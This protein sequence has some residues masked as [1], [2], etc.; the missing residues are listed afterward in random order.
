MGARVYHIDDPSSQRRICLATRACRDVESIQGLYGRKTSLATKHLKDAHDITSAQTTIE[1][2]RKLS[3]DEEANHILVSATTRQDCQRRV[4]LLLQ[5]L[6][7]VHN[8]FPFVVG[9]WEE[10]QLLKAAITKE[11]PPAVVNRQTVILLV[12]ELYASAKFEM[13]HFLKR[14]RLHG[15]RYLVM[16]TDFWR[17]KVTGT[18]Y[19]G[20]RVYVIDA[21]WKFGSILLGTRYFRPMHGERIQGNREAFA[22]WI[23]HLLL[24]FKLSPSD[25]F[26]ATADGSADMK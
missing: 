12:I 7:T 20:L 24:D 18:K 14:N 16:V 13:T 8:N 25:F 3:Q 6:Q 5:T 26:G 15:V 22:R 17:C 9:E 21:N 11:K 10:S 4:S 19:L 23:N 2:T 1:D